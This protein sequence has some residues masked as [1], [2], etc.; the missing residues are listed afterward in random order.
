MIGQQGAGAKEGGEPSMSY[1]EACEA[2]YGALP[3]F[4][5]TGP[6]AYKIDLSGT[7]AVMAFLG[8]PDSQM[9][10][11]IHVAGT[12]GKG[13]VCTMVAHALQLAGHRVGLFTS[14][15]LVDLR[16]RIRVNGACIPEDKVTAMVADFLARSEG[17]FPSGPPSFFEM[18]FGMACLHFVAEQCD[19]VV[20]ETG[21]GG[22]LDSTNIFA[23]PLVTAI[24]NVGL[25]HQ[26]F[27]GPDI[28]S[29]A[30]EKAG[31]VKDG[32]PVVMG[33]M[34]PE[35]QSVVLTQALR[36]GAEVHYAP[37]ADR[38]A[39]AT[40]AHQGSPYRAENEAT[41]LKVLE[42]LG[43]EHPAFRLS[44]QAARVGV[45]SAVWPGRWQW[46]EE[47]AQGARVLV[48]CAHN[49]DG[50]AEWLRGFAALGV[51]PAKVQLV[52]GTV[53]DKDLSAIQA[54]LP[55][56]FGGYCWCAADIPRALSAVDLQAS[57]A[58]WGPAVA[59]ESVADAFAAA[60][61]AAPSGG[62]VAV[63]GSIFVAA[64]ALAAAGQAICQSA[65]SSD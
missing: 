19:V 46:L 37:V 44:E 49:A 61:H 20:L 56:D 52:F 29:I 53:S 28:R 63:V 60:C 62:L 65:E 47:T 48:D 41:A 38:T 2:L 31:I 24:T 34:R 10:P 43:A 30:A 23:K 54:V 1:A 12:N 21:M 64:E 15:H 51:E 14:P 42:V 27:L 4:Q 39:E 58:S 33:R 35:A 40:A 5:R 32:V 18:T 59:H 7:R 26:A 22:R 55:R 50:M 25:D 3:M 45:Q 9:P 13:S 57:M 8:R 16:E 6:A 11:V 36:V 17:A